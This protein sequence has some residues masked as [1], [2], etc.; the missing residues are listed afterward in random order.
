MHQLPPQPDYFR[1]KVWRRLRAIGAAP[2]KNSVY[3]LANTPEA[4]EDFEWLSREIVAGKGE[5]TLCE[6]NMISGTTDKEVE[7]LIAHSTKDRSSQAARARRS[8]PVM[9]S[10]PRRATWVT[11]RNVHVDRI[12]SAW[13]I[14]R[15]IDPGAKFKF[16]ESVGYRRKSAELRFDMFDAEFTHVGASCTFEVLIQA[17]GLKR[18]QALRAVSEIVHD[19][20]C[21]DDAFGR[22]ET[23]QTADELSLIYTSH[24][25]DLARLE[26]G[27][28]LFEGLY[29]MFGGRLT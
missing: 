5:A 8:V 25:S 3:V 12:A 7:L 24:A 21:K 6:A 18:N 1:V 13:L 17:F 11:R 20:D 29:A 2:L 22:E 23:R 27:A 16:V 10:R 9:R 4:R 26:Y 19:I 14:R 15:F 28:T